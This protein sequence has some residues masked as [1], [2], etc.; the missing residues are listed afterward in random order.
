M[1]FN[2]RF[3]SLRKENRLTQGEVASSLNVSISTITMWETGHRHPTVSA[4]LDISKIFKVSTDYL[5]GTSDIR[6]TS[7]HLENTRY[8]IPITEKMAILDDYGKKNVSLLINNEFQRC[9][10]Q[11]TLVQDGQSGENIT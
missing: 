5:L 6:K 11:G 1:Q 9:V 2:E 8:S 4:L 3:K 10:G 7:D